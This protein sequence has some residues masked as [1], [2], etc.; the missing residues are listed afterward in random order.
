[1]LTDAATLAGTIFAL[2]ASKISG[3][4]VDLDELG[5]VY[6]NSKRAQDGT[7]IDAVPVRRELHPVGE[8]LRNVVHEVLSG[9]SM[10][11]A[12]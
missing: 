4:T 3:G 9:F 5:V 10:T 11:S 1:M 7:E 2:R 12:D 8:P 6:V